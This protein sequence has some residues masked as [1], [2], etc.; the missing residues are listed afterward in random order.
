MPAKPSINAGRLAAGRSARET[1]RA[2]PVVELDAPPAH[3]G[4]EARKPIPATVR[5]VEQHVAGTRGAVTEREVARGMSEKPG[6]MP[7]ARR[8]RRRRVAVDSRRP[9]QRCRA[10]A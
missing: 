2:G 9:E 10:E 7:L 3:L 1:P 6:Y 4:C 8:N 5:R